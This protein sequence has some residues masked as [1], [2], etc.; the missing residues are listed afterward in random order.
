MTSSSAGSISR[1]GEF[2][3]DVRLD[4]APGT[5][6]TAKGTVPLALFDRHL[7]ERA[8]DVAIVSSPIDLGLLAGVTDVVNRATG[9]MRLEVRAIGT[10]ARSSFRGIDRHGERRVRRDGDRSRVQERPRRD[11]AR[12]GPYHRRVVPSRGRGRTAARRARQ[13]R[14]ARAARR[15]SCDR[16]DGRP[17]PSPPQRVRRPGH[18][19]DADAAGTVRSTEAGRRPHDCGR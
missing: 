4:Q 11:T 8:I 16:H 1:Q 13:S 2:T 12:R 7:P 18:Q 17:L 9:Q 15:R 19:R 5:W 14:H 3:I 10:S 6:L